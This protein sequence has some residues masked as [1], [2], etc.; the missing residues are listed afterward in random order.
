MI[1]CDYQT[2]ICIGYIILYNKICTLHYNDKFH[3]FF[4]V[5]LDRLLL[6][7]TINAWRKLRGH[8]HGDMRP[9]NWPIVYR[10]KFSLFSCATCTKTFFFWG[11][12]PDSPLERGTP[13]SAGPYLALRHAL[14]RFAPSVPRSGPSATQSSNCFP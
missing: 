11:N 7:I 14:R 6:I 10:L 8:G 9:N 12:A 13:L 2:R 5:Y 1:E 4:K 3:Y